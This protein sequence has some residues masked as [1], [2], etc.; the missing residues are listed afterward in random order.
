MD[1]YDDDLA[2]AIALSLDS[3]NQTHNDDEAP[4][5]NN[6]SDRMDVEDDYED[7]LKRA[8]EASKGAGA[9]E[10]SDA[11]PVANNVT[12]NDDDDYED[13]LRMAI[14]ASKASMS[15]SMSRGASVS[16]PASSA[17]SASPPPPSTTTTS[18]TIQTTSATTQFL[19]ERAKLEKE[20]LERQKRL[21]KA[22]GL[23]TSDDDER[24]SKGKG[25]KKDVAADDDGEEDSDEDEGE[26]QPSKKRQRVGSGVGTGAGAGASR[27]GAGARDGGGSVSDADGLGLFWNGELRP[28]ATRGSE[29]R[30]DGRPTFRLTE[31]LGQKTSIAFAIIST[32]ALDLSWI[33]SFF[34]PAIPVILVSQPEASGNSSMK[35]VLPNWIKTTPFLRGGFGCM[36][37]KIF[38]KTGRLRIA[39]TTANLVDFDWRDIE[40]AAWIQDLPPVPTPASFDKKNT[41]SFQY[42]MKRVLDAVNVKPALEVMKKQG[43]PNLPISQT[44]DICTRWDWS[45]V[46]VA[47]VP[48]IA[49]RHE[50][51]SGVLM[52]G[53]TRLMKALRNMGCRTGTGTGAASS[54]I[55]TTKTTSKTKTKVKVSTPESLS[56]SL[57]GS[58][59]GQYTTQWLNEFYY[60]ARGESP[61]DWLDKMTRKKREKLPFPKEEEIMIVFP[62]GRRVKESLWGERGG[63]TIFC[64]RSQWEAANFPRHLFRESRSRAGNNLMH[65]KM[66]IGVLS[67]PPKNETKTRTMLSKSKTASKAKSS[68]AAS[69]SSKATG[70]GKARAEP[71]VIDL[72]SSSDEDNADDSVTESETESESDSD[73]LE[74]VD[75]PVGWIYIGSHNFTPSAWGTLSGSAFNPVLNIRNY[76]LG[77]VF[78]VRSQ[79][80]IERLALFERPPQKYKAGDT[81]WFQDESEYFRIS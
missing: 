69:F 26:G 19:S 7:Q 10:A 12:N 42:V 16:L 23:D 13:E 56:I 50:G 45:K 8:I 66:I 39:V 15:S 32:F 81:P 4:V 49:G 11:Q 28:T 40:N 78:P 2:R 60:S 54:S 58:S 34:D 75:Q 57:L 70:K 46:K 59:I 33:Y 63:G 67:D 22:Q 38:Y 25:K 31:I 41:E 35:N 3:V 64:K 74:L 77:I 24:N 76:E 37:M 73:G 43:H 62:S 5:A 14:E 55:K 30:K 61:E 18:N 6:E 65:T 47:L 80:E 79:A 71:E 27:P 17:S 68:T 52:N 51:W 9:G 44:S 53:H 20:R 72:V 21:R 1:R 29:P 36:H 48:S